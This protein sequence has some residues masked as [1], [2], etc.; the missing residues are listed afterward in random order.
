MKRM[1]TDDAFEKD[2]GFCRGQII[3]VSG[4]SHYRIT[5]A[6]DGLLTLR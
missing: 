2:C 1:M 3:K 4:G 6:E 5:D